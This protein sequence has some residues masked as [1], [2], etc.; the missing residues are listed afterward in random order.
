MSM[1][2]QWDQLAYYDEKGAPQCRLA[3]SITAEHGRQDLDDQAQADLVWSDGSPLT[4][5][6]V[7]FSWKL[8]PTRTSPT[9]RACGSN[10]VG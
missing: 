8:G 9:T 5:D 4:A 6:D 2:L 1:E 3:D 7:I 10:V